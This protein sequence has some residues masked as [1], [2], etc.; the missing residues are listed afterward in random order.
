MALKSLPDCKKPARSLKRETLY[1]VS[2]EPETETSEKAAVKACK[3]L[4]VA[5]A[6]RDTA[7]PCGLP[8]I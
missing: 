1:H 5:G 4:E 8:R 2:G 6:E 3:Q 7:V